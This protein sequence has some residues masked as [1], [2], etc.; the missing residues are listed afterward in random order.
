MSVNFADLLSTPGAASLFDSSTQASTLSHNDYSS[1]VDLSLVDFDYITQCN[2]PPTL[3]SI[4]QQ[5]E[6]EPFPELLIAARHRLLEVDESTRLAVDRKR[7]EGD[8]RRVVCSELEQWVIQQRQKEL[9]NPSVD[10]HKPLRQHPPIRSSTSRQPAA[11]GA[12]QP[13]IALPAVA[14][15]RVAVEGGMSE[16]EKRRRVASEKQKGNECYKAGEYST[17][18]EHYTAAIA[19]LPPPYN[20]DATTVHPTSFASSLSSVSPADGGTYD[21]SLHTNLA[22]SQLRLSHYQLAVN[23]ASAAL[24]HSHGTAVKAWW[25]R[26]Q[27]YRKLNQHADALRDYQ[28][29]VQRAHDTTLQHEIQRDMHSLQ[30]DMATAANR[31]QAASSREAE[32]KD[33][34][35]EDER[36]QKTQ[37][38]TVLK[39]MTIVEGDSDDEE[40]EEAAEEEKSNSQPLFKAPRGGMTI[41]VLSEQ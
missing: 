2:H 39:R 4:I 18:A 16:E 20:T 34:R 17:A 29:A 9:V 19:L 12:A 27:A 37:A 24:T 31:Q 7:R 13:A 23:T 11:A 1:H 5:L 28:Q 8:E 40:A 30:A 21:F 6:H 25:R 3:H 36:K 22:M 41:E 15:G 35:V 38:D 33:G 14:G 10:V 32:E 26:A